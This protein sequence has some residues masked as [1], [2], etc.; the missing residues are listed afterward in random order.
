MAIT[1][2][3]RDSKGEIRAVDDER[4]TDTKEKMATILK[5]YNSSSGK[6]MILLQTGIKVASAIVTVIEG[7]MGA[8]KSPTLQLVKQAGGTIWKTIYQ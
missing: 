6:S 5:K 1:I 8:K 3:F 4:S 7:G 2:Q